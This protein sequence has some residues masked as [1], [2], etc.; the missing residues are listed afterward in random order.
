M[1]FNLFKSA[2]SRLYQ[3][4][5][6][7]T[8]RSRTLV[9]NFLALSDNIRCNARA[10]AS[11][12]AVITEGEQFKLVYT[13]PWH[14][15]KR[16]YEA[17]ISSNVWLEYHCYFQCSITTLVSSPPLYPSLSSLVGS[18]LNVLQC[19]YP[20]FTLWHKIECEKV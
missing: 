10:V 11:G 5:C 18:F 7:V 20:I 15:M 14:G 9:K 12:C 1:L 4:T 2:L 13:T 8:E 3:Q 16:Y 19:E 6:F 17:R